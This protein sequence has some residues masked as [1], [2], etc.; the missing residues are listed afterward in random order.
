MTDT[1]PSSQADPDT[2]KIFLRPDGTNWQIFVEA[3]GIPGGFKLRRLL[4]VCFLCACGEAIL[5]DELYR[6]QEPLYVQTQGSH[7]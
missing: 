1:L 7:R 5:I 4:K 6:K 2:P 3:G